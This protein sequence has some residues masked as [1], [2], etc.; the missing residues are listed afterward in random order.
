[1]EQMRYVRDISWL[2]I[3]VLRDFSQEMNDFLK[4]STS[5]VDSSLP[6]ER[7][8]AVCQLFNVS[9]Q[10]PPGHEHGGVEPHPRLLQ[11]PDHRE[12]LLE[13]GELVPLVPGHVM[14]QDD[15]AVLQVP[16]QGPLQPGF[17]QEIG[18]IVDPITEPDG[19]SFIGIL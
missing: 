14:P 19:T 3:D 11:P 6:P 5:V 4:K 16:M 17:D 18:P 12:P 9:G 15:L 7:I 8:D 1:M 13:E 10:R 2:N